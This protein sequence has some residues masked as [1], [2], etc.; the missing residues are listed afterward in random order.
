MTRC[1][2]SVLT[3]LLQPTFGGS[4]ADFD[5]NAA[6]SAEEMTPETTPR[7]WWEAAGPNRETFT[8]FDETIAYMRGIL[9]KDEQGFDVG[10]SLN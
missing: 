10:L 9:D 8:G 6:A 3:P 2:H 5:S 1:W 7:S 4:L